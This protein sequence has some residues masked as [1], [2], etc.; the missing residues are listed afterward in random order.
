MTVAF[1]PSTVSRGTFEVI[2]GFLH[3]RAGIMLTDSK[4]YLIESRLKP[5]AARHGLDSLADLAAQLLARGLKADAVAAD[6][7]E[8][9]P[10]HETVLFRGEQPVP[11]LRTVALPA[12]HAAR[13]PGQTIRIW[14]AASSSGQE[15]YSVAM[16]IAEMPQ[17]AGRS[18]ELIGTDLSREQVER[19]GA[20]LY[21]HFEVQRG[22]PVQMLVK[23]FDR[24]DKSWRVKQRLREK[25]SFREWN[26]MGDPSRLGKFDIVFCRNVLIYF[27]QATKTQVLTRI[28]GQM[29]SDGY[30][31][32]GGAETV[33]GMTTPFIA[34]PGEAAFRLAPAVAKDARQRPEMMRSTS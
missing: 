29:P 12:L 11:P 26:L 22:L 4:L 3:T 10:P 33:V 31:Y 6:V 5:V 15:A 16:I 34:Q 30:L 9:M 24:E 2:A 20:G 21:S 7:I 8:A 1:S 18:V 27:D 13:P 19:A 14:S 25:V 17:L 23:H 32:L 28:A